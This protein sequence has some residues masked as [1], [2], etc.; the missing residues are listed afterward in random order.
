MKPHDA[1]IVGSGP[2]GIAAAR[3]LAEGGLRVTV[4]EAGS[5]IIDPPGSH[6]RNQARFRQDPDS[7]FA[8]IAPYFAP[9]PATCRAPPIR[10]C[11][12]ARA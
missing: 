7:F 6:F 9:S 2:V 8:A 1:L 3:R 10:R 11:S 5:A 4:I 12:A